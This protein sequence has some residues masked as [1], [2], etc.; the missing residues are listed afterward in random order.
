MADRNYQKGQVDAKQD[1]VDQKTTEREQIQSLWDQQDS[2][3]KQFAAAHPDEENP[4][5]PN[6]FDETLQAKEQELKDAEKNLGLAESD[7][8][9]YQRIF[10]EKKQIYDDLLAFGNEDEFTESV[11]R[12]STEI[13]FY[14][15]DLKTLRRTYARQKS[16]L[17]TA[18]QRRDYLYA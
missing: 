5:E 9:I 7:L 10:D 4:F 12:V 17:M 8:R 6:Q 13:A 14:E 3:A 18:T 2:L 16:Q 15:E 1:L 11:H